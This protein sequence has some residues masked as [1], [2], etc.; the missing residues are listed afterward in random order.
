MVL[1]DDVPT[2]TWELSH[3]V[4]GDD[5]LVTTFCIY[6]AP[7]EQEIHEHAKRLGSHTVAVARDR[8]RRHAGRLSDRRVLV[9]VASDELVLV[10]AL[11]PT[12]QL[13]RDLLTEA[14]G[15]VLACSHR[16]LALPHGDRHPGAALA[17][18]EHLDALQPWLRRDPVR[19]GVELLDQ[20]LDL[21]DREL[22]R[23]DASPHL[24]PS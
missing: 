24:V 1:R 6:D 8:R 15:L 3:V 19:A 20:L 9:V 14:V 18:H 22:V 17:A 13:E 2:V 4:V 7:S 21:R 10:D 5:G 23:A 12:D 11:D 16:V